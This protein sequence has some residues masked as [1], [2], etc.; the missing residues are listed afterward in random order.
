MRVPNPNI[1]SSSVQH[2]VVLVT[3]GLVSGLVLSLFSYS[4]FTGLERPHQDAASTVSSDSATDGV[5]TA[6]ALLERLASDE[7]SNT[8]FITSD[9]LKISEDLQTVN[10]EELVKALGRSASLPYTRNLHPI[11]EMLCEYLVER[12]PSEALRS[13]WLFEE[14]RKVALLRVVVRGWALHDMEE[15]FTVAIGLQQPYKEIAIETILSELDATDEVFSVPQSSDYDEIEKYRADQTYELEIYKTISRDPSAALDLL[16][17]DNAEDSEQAD[18]FSQAFNEMFQLEG[19]NAITQLNFLSFDREFFDELLLQIIE[20]DRLGMISYLQNLSS[21]KRSRFMY[22]LMDNWVEVDVENVLPAVENL[23]NPTYR[24]STYWA[25]VSSWGR[26][27][28]LE[29]LNRLP[30]IPREHRDSAVFYAFNTLG[31]T[32]PDAVLSLLSSLKAIPGAFNEENERTFVYSWSSKFP[33]QALMWVQENIEPE[34]TQ[35]NWMLSRVLGEY[36]LVQ[37][38]EAMEVAITEDPNPARGELGLAYNVIESLASDGQLD[39]AIGL[40]DQVPKHNRAYIYAEVAEKLVLK[41]RLSEVMSLSNRLPAA[42]RVDY[43]HS[44][45]T[46]LSY[47]HSSA[48]LTLVAKIPDTL[49]RTDVVNQILSDTWMIEEYYTEGQ[50]ESLRSL[51]T[52]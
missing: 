3:I 50:R 45:A 5:N 48:V 23:S 26:I 7:T 49:L 33:D 38:K 16:L 25:L 41:D 19:F 15:S 40:L 32:N 11:Q 20:Q 13:V 44:V 37:P 22:L 21:T 24:A 35:R 34:T 27:R 6:D 18:L 36:A 30:E 28:P 29:L 4:V 9:F 14:H 2:K 39:T 12:S 52:E 8:D 10:T 46:K 1:D 42:E 31:K 51:V 47:N 17:K 43:F